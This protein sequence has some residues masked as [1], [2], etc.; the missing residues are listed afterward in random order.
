[1]DGKGKI[2]RLEGRSEAEIKKIV[3]SSW[4]D[5]SDLEKLPYVK[6][7]IIYEN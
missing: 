6:K 3:I 7:S 1:M 2:L 5:M 4:N